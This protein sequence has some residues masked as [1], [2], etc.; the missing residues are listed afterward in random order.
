MWRLVVIVGALVLGGRA[1]ADPPGE[2]QVAPPVASGLADP[3]AE[4]DPQGGLF[5]DKNP[6]QAAQDQAK[7][8]KSAEEQAKDARLAAYNSANANKVARVVVLQQGDADYSNEALQRNI[9]NR[10][11]RTNAKFF[12]DV[13]L[14]QRGR[15]MPHSETLRP[16]DQLAV[17]PD[18]VIPKLQS[19]VAE[20][21]AIPYDGMSEQDWGLQA[22]KMLKLLDEAWFLDRPALKEPIFLMY[23]YIGYAAENTNDHSPPYYANVDGKSVNYYWYLAGTLAYDDPAL[24]S[25]ITNKELYQSV[26]YY[27]DQIDSGKFNQMKL[28]FASNGKFDSDKF[29][30]DFQVLVNGVEKQIKNA[31]GLLEVPM[32][33]ADIQLKRSDG[34]SLSERVDHNTLPDRFDLVVDAA[35][36]R[37]G[38]DFVEQL[39]EHKSDC[40]PQLSGD[41]VNYLSIYAKLH[42]DDDVYIAVPFL[43]SVAPGRILLWRWDRPTSVL[44][45]VQDNTG[46]FPVRF[47]IELGAGLAFSGATFTPPSQED[48]QG[49][50]N[51]TPPSDAASAG[52]G[53][54]QSAIG[55]VSNLLKPTVDGAPVFYQLRGH[56]NHLTV[57]VGMQY[58][59]GM[60]PGA[61]ANGQYVD[62]Y[63]TD[64]NVVIK[65]C[66]DDGTGSTASRQAAGTGGTDTGTC[67]QTFALRERKLQRLV[68]M[69]AGAT[70]GKDSAVGF[71]P[72]VFLRTGWYNAPHA[73]DLTLHPGLTT[74]ITGKKDDERSGRVR[75]LA[76]FDLYGGMLLPVKDTTLIPVTRS[77]FLTIGKPI[78]TLGFQAGVGLT[79]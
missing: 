23:V 70:F 79:F 60:A 51:P 48:L 17:V 50:L 49:Q 29:I 54:Q 28:G 11:G 55:D 61:G 18:S 7:Q 20:T 77:G 57:G 36:T 66:G 2:P 46:G 44:F 67:D 42:P 33:I 56:Y 10:I 26:S 65:P 71:G 3:P 69:L 22:S 59:L 39:T 1:W 78:L 64:G 62:L 38:I 27:K 52:Q 13:D 68:Y 75:A 74:A 31:N 34:Y 9:K 32:G 37:M 5:G 35:K 14:Y 25:K 58:K 4:P 76:D 12:P 63:Q 47:E 45:L 6:I 16:S 41:I 24:L 40:M 21:A 15:L 73:V 43:G 53:L 72:H 8:E 19:M 30:G